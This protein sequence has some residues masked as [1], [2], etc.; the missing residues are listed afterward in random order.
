MGIRGYPDRIR[1]INAVFGFEIEG[2]GGGFWTLDCTS[3]PPSIT[4]GNPG[5]CQC[6]ITIHHDDFRRFFTDY[7]VGIDLYFDNKIRV[8]GNEK[9]CLKLGAFFAITRPK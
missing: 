5:N 3:T 7:N 6:T 9:L 1:E 2:D 4:P 8:T